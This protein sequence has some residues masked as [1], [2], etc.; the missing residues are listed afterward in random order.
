MTTNNLL[1]TPET[2]IPHPYFKT[3]PPAEEDGSNGLRFVTVPGGCV[4]ITESAQELFEIIG[5]KN[6]LFYRG[7]SV[8][9]IVKDKD[10]NYNLQVVNAVAAQSRFEQFAIFQ[11]RKKILDSYMSARTVISERIAKQYL[12]SKECRTLL[13]TLSGIVHCPVLIEDN[14]TLHRVDEGYD[15][16]SGFF[17][18]SSGPAEQVLFHDAVELL[19]G[20]L[21]EFD[22]VTPGD[23]SRAIASLITPAL[24][25][26]GFIKG[27]IPIDVAEANDSQSGKTYRQKMVAALYNQRPATVTK[28]GGGVGSMEETFNDHLI[29][30]RVFI[31]F[32]N[33][34]GRLDSQFLEAFVTA[35]SGFGARIPFS[36]TITVDPAKFI[37][38]ISSNGFEATRDLTN[39]SSIIRIRKREGYQ[40][41][42]IDGR[43]MLQFIFDFQPLL[44]GAVFSI[45]QEWHRLGK[46][47]TNETRHDFREWCQTLDWIVQHL[48]G[49]APLMDGHEAAK[50]RAA[51]PHLTFL[52]TV[53][54]KIQEHQ[55]LDQRVSATDITEMCLEH[56]IELPGLTAD[57]HGLEEGRKQIGRIMGKLFGQ[58]DELLVDEFKVTKQDTMSRTM[59][60]ND[61]KLTR[62]TFSSANPGAQNIPSP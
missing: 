44:I 11:A 22:F 49:A 45:I 7:G 20:L 42:T 9:E 21:S 57:K 60:G 10:D 53:A 2:E 33:V 52:R 61:Q 6:I 13:P 24:K 30:G 58:S 29:K 41:R 5:P 36:P 3:P 17:V 4:T 51:S 32:D 48:F 35:D 26:G 14:G 56:G 18:V 62:Y 55:K 28:K 50:Q 1:P 37:L 31:Q 46:Q 34:R 47:R 15:E 39:R 59:T 27:P 23:R 43:D 40:F 54:L 25:L 16:K 38:F 8:V 12:N 19:T